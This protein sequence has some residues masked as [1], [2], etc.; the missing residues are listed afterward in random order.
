M[1]IIP[2]LLILLS[3]CLVATGQQ[4][5]TPEQAREAICQ[6]VAC[7]PV[8]TVRLKLNDKQYFEME[9]PADLTSPRD[10]STQAPEFRNMAVSG[11]S[12]RSFKCSLC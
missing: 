12:G 1:R 8:T 5:Q 3:T 9:F 6:R 4:Q 7:R 10:S 11:C 2:T